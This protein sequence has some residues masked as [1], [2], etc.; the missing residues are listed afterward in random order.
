MDPNKVNQDSYITSP[1][2][3]NQ[4][5]LHYFGVCDGH[6]ANGHLVSQY[7]K[8]NLPTALE[9]IKYVQDNPKQQ[10]MNV[11]KSIADRLPGDLNVDLSMSGSTSVGVYLNHNKLYCCNLG[12]SKAVLGSK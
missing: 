11:F 8:K 6:G 12:D 5:W 3:N 7:V 1:N 9:K 2:L 4:T 10:F